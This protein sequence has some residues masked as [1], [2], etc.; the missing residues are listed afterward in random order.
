MYFWNLENGVCSETRGMM[1]DIARV[2]E[3]KV[4][5]GIVNIE[6]NP[7]IAQVY[8]VKR[9]PLLAVFQEG[10]M[11]IE[12]R[13]IADER[14][15]FLQ[16]IQDNY[17]DLPEG[18]FP[19]IKKYTEI[20][21]RNISE[22]LE[23]K[24]VVVIYF[25]DWEDGICEQ[26]KEAIQRVSEPVEE[27]MLIGISN[28]ELNPTLARICEGTKG[29][30]LNVLQKGEIVYT[31]KGTVEDR[32]EFLRFLQQVEISYL[33][34]SKEEENT[35]YREITDENFVEVF[36]KHFLVI[37]YFWSLETGICEITKR[38]MTQLAKPLEGK[39]LMGI[40]NVEENPTLANACEIKNSPILKIIRNG[41]IIHDN[42][43][44]IEERVLCLELLKEVI[45]EYWAQ[46]IQHVSSCENKETEVQ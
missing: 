27:N 2:L 1:R 41:R 24:E 22:I 35:L 8:K 39:A 33:C 43:G 15:Q 37:L 9:G 7:K 20:T 16:T 30:V 23:Q 5:V 21:D 17:P 14:K 6:K 46:I 40:S 31:K 3:K 18:S 4:F 12:F 32:I 42:D 13:G 45:N 25:W 11:Q 29:P 44:D 36:Q 26:T 38:T 28:R 34:F 10:V 19:K